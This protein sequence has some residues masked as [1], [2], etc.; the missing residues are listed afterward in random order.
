MVDPGLRPSAPGFPR[1]GS[2]AGVN[3]LD[4]LRNVP[5][6]ICRALT[7]LGDLGG[8]WKLRGIEALRPAGTEQ[9]ADPRQARRPEWRGWIGGVEGT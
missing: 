7:P 1:V 5:R 2:E 8:K 6:V 4:S 3:A 9:R